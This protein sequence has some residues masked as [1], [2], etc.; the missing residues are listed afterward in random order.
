MSPL[1]PR[2]LALSGSRF[3]RYHWE[4]RSPARDRPREHDEARNPPRVPEHAGP[5][6][7]RRDLDDPLDQERAAPRNL[8]ELPSLL[9]GQTEA[10]RRRRSGRTF[11]P[12]VRQEDERDLQED[13]PS[14]GLRAAPPRGRDHLPEAEGHR[15]PPR[16][17]RDPDV[18]LR[19]GPGPPGLPAARQGVEGDLP[20]RGALPRLQGDPPGADQGQGDG[21]GGVGP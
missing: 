2:G 11:H 13:N 9:Y 18:R 3:F 5:L 1:T 17:G 6:R 4:L 19:G 21:A 16:R 7:L 10:H 20:H 12:Q 14:A 15:G 8:L